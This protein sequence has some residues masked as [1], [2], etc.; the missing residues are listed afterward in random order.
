MVE[1]CGRCW[2]GVHAVHTITEEDIVP[3]VSQVRGTIAKHSMFGRGDTVVV[4]VSGGV[5]SMALLHVLVELRD[6]YALQLHVAHLNHGFRGEEADA[7]A[8]LVEAAAG[9]LRIPATV[10]KFDVPGF[11][12]RMRLGAQEAARNARYEFLE[13]VASRIGADKVATGHTASD[14][15]E[16]VLINLLRGSGALGLGGIPPVRGRVVRPLIEVTKDEVWEFARRGGIACREDSSNAKSV[17]LR[18][19]IRSRLLPL[20][21]AEF[22]PQIVSVLARTA[23]LLREDERHLQNDSEAA[24]QKVVVSVE[25]GEKIAVDLGALLSY[26]ISLRRR[27][28]R[29]LVIMFR[30][31]PRGPS[32]EEIE[33]LMRLTRRPGGSARL[34]L[35]SGM[36]AE[37]LY[38]R[39]LLTRQADPMPTGAV[40]EALEIPGVTRVAPLGLTVEARVF[41]RSGL[42][43]DLRKTRSSMAYFDHEQI[44]SPVVVR[45]RSPGDT[46]QPMGMPG[47]RKLKRVFIDDK[48]PRATRD[49]IPLLADARG[50]FWIVGHRISE[51]VKVNPDTREVLW[52][53]VLEDAAVQ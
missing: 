19:L 25:P 51:R 1:R 42:P 32:F 43:D 7:D 41:G 12:S 38:G 30:G 23:E 13:G 50:V 45:V 11:A 40:L 5:D 53:K 8:A 49:Q 46:F 18:N 26:D 20:L 4:G 14:Q 31:D 2:E 47:S 34:D 52:V 36:Y 33:N 44:V 9:D 28:L 6:E 16:T 17:Y 48:I 35:G 29:E 37:R 21:A 27:I 24:L 10:Q 39:L 15:A 3:F 22:N